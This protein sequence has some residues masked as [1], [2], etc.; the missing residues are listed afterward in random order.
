M[1][2]PARVRALWDF[3]VKVHRGN[4]EGRRSAVLHESALYTFFLIRNFSISFICAGLLFV[5][6]PLYELI[7]NNNKILMVN[8]YL[9]F[10][11][12][13]QSR[14]YLL[15][16]LYQIIISAYGIFG[17][18]AYDMFLAMIVSNYQGIVSIWECQ[19]QELVK[20]NR[21]KSTP[22]NRAYRK[23]FLRNVFIQLLDATR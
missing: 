14:G 19:L 7:F 16:I 12:V 10:V 6:N 9:P 18:M 11:N 2:A 17:N 4:T 21:L 20:V 13:K 1:L 22:K 15:T 8:I 23:A 3:V 5:L